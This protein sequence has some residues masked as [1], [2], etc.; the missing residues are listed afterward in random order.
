MAIHE[1]RLMYGQVLTMKE[2]FQIMTNRSLGQLKRESEIANLLTTRYVFDEMRELQ[3]WFKEYI[4]E[5]AFLPAGMT[6]DL[7][8]A[9]QCQRAKLSFPSVVIG[10]IYA[11]YERNDFSPAFPLEEL[12]PSSRLMAEYE[13]LIQQIPHARLAKRMQA[14]PTPPKVV[15]V[16]DECECC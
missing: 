12:Q 13:D 14:A 1:W 15:L 3:A 11:T 2:F 8:T 4:R 6:Y 5:N 10:M 9:S 7:L 16:V